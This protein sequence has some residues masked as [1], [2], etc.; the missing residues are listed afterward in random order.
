[1]AI[2][3]ILGGIFLLAATLALISEVTHA[4]LGVPGAP[5]TPVLDQLAA[6]TPKLLQSIERGTR[7]LHV[8]LWDPVLRSLLTLPAWVS[9]GTIGFV[10]G[11]LGRRRRHRISVY[12]N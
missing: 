8:L 11:W 7:S 4:Q 10:L 5:F 12:T 1:M 6:S 3:R 9:L 2:L